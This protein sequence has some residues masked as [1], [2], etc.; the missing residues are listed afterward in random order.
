MD[1]YGLTYSLYHLQ[2]SVKNE[3]M[4]CNV[5]LGFF[6]RLKSM[7]ELDEALRKRRRSWLR[8]IITLNLDQ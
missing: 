5:L 3:L 1:M 8:Q 6:F 2:G 4:F 7:Q